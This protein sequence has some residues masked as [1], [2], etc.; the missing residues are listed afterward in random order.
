MGDDKQAPE[1][2]KGLDAKN[3]AKATGCAIAAGS[4]AEFSK[5]IFLKFLST[6]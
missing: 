2:K 4:C 3:F 1:P 6:V 5:C